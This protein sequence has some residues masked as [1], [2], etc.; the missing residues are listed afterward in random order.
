M[1]LT[2]THCHLDFSH[3]DNDRQAV[4]SRAWDSGLI[5]ILIPGVDIAT[6]Q[7]AVQIASAEARIF[8]AIG[9]HPNSSNTWN[10]DSLSDLQL[11]ASRKKVVAVGEIGLD[12]YRDRAPRQ[13]QR[14]VFQKQLLLAQELGVP[15]IIHT[16]NT[17]P[18]ERSCIKDVIAII[19]DWNPVIKYPGVVH[20]YSGNQNEAEKL[21]SLGF[22]IGITGPVTYKNASSLKE[23]VAS[24]PIE[25]L[26]IETDGP[27]LTPHP[28][29]GKRNEP[30]Y[31]QYIGEEI[32]RLKK[33]P[34]EAVYWQTAVNADNLFGWGL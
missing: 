16:R 33:Q 23:I 1:V 29:R 18:E 22:M 7:R 26:L 11:L 32:S 10:N 13:L 8:T 28:H 9:V 3:Y 4:L 15:V 12:Y 14:A 27:F 5:R 21:L 17:S 19:E 30:A 2:D 6:S 24:L 20:S 25:S 31:V 34:V